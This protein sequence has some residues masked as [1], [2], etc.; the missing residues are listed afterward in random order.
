[1]SCAAEARSL[2]PCGGVLADAWAGLACGRFGGPAGVARNGAARLG[3]VALEERSIHLSGDPKAKTA[4]IARTPTTVSHV[5]SCVL[6][7]E[8]SCGKS[9]VSAAFA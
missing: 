8:E 1:M 4:A 9:T 6:F 7:P 3:P 2:S 5:I